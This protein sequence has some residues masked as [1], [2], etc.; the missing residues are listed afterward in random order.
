MSNDGRFYELLDREQERLFYPSLRRAVA[1]EAD[2]LA[3]DGAVEQLDT[4]ALEARYR[5]VGH[6][7]YPPKVILKVLIYGYSIGLRSSRDLERSCRM[8]AAF[9]FLA[10]GLEPDHATLCRFRRQHP[11][12]LKELFVQ[13]VRLCRQA[14]LVQLGHV[15]VDGTKMRANRSTRELRRATEAVE[16]AILEAEEADA[17]IPA[18]DEECRLMK[19]QDGIKPAYNAQ[20]A[21]DSAHQVIVAQELVAAETDYG[22][23]PEMVEQVKENCH[24]PPQAVSADGGYLSRDSLEHLDNQGIATYLPVRE[25]EAEKF[26]WVEEKQA[27]RCPAG[28]LLT[29]HRVREGR[30]IYRTHRCR[31][32]PLAK[33]C[34]VRGRFKE[35]SVPLSETGLGKLAQRMSTPEGQAIYAQRK[36]IV[37]PVF[38]CFKHNRGFWR[39]LLRGRRRAGGELSLMCIAHNLGKWTRAAWLASD[40]AGLRVSSLREP[41]LSGRPCWQRAHQVFHRLLVLGAQ[42]SSLRG[43]LVALRRPLSH[44]PIWYPNLAICSCRK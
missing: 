33:D 38:G 3:L 30:Q 20:V 25:R 1:G 28:R 18:E 24:A 16:Q 26:E 13:T 36:R 4:C 12:Q 39:F 15:A 9:Q 31:G 14:G 37:E 19:T 17:D 44:P 35:V 32:C 43:R 11:E 42:A 5:R 41:R 6:P 21:V 22:Q 27:F 34:G 10:H 40:E 29:A 2:V 23:L 7:A 8:D